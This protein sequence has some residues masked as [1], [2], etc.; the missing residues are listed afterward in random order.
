MTEY[1]IGTYKFQSET[2]EDA[3]KIA[4]RKMFEKGWRNLRLMSK[5]KDGWGVCRFIPEYENR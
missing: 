3:L 1:M 2:V 4:K 5:G